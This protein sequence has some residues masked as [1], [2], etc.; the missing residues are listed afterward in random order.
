MAGRPQGI[1]AESGVG[2]LGVQRNGSDPKQL[3][4]TLIYDYF[5]KSRQPDLAQNLLDSPLHVNTK[6]RTKTSPSGRDVNGFNDSGDS[7]P[8]D[9]IAKRIETMPVAELHEQLPNESF[10]QDWFNSFWDVWSASR[11]MAQNPSGTAAQYLNSAQVFFRSIP[12][13][14][15]L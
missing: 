2:P 4:P 9:E 6:P 15:K 8:R 13:V 10:L 5:L 14:S 3:L 12:W 11:N 1:K 7:E